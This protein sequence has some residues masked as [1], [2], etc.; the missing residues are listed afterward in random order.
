LKKNKL[1][2]SIIVLDTL[3]LDMFNKLIKHNPDLFKGFN[4]VIF[5]NCISPGS[6][7][8]PSHASMFTGL[9]QSQ[10]GCHET[11]QIKSLDIERIKLRKDTILQDLKAIGYSTY[12]VSANPYVHP[13]YG[14]TG[15]DEYIEESYFTDI[16]GSVIEVSR[17]LKPRVSKYR[18]IYGNDVFNLSKAIMKE[19]PKLFLDLVVSAT[20]LTPKAAIK[21]TKAKLIEGWPIEKGGKSMLKKIGAIKFKEPFFLFVNF[22]EA[23]DPYVGGKGNDF[24]WVT[25][26]L[27]EG[28]DEMLINKWKT[29]YEKASYKALKYSSELVKQLIKR[30]GEDQIIILTSD[31]GQLFN[32]HNFIGHGTVIFDEIVKVPLMVIVPE[33]FNKNI[34]KSGYQSL[35]NFPQFIKSVIAND[36]DPLSKLSS[37]KVYAETFSI[38]A[39]ISHMKGLDKRKMA[40]FDKYQK[41]SFG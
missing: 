18:N 10:H 3:K 26:F 14:F 20:T 24:N 8:L 7:T 41:R 29:L 38:P 33:S 22:M 17:E 13:V 40:K 21:K 34:K 31:H 2:I 27:K 19:D 15:F 5:Q 37:K 23:H 35:V 6:W 36:A 9:S 4:A 32:E 1:N 16:F 12:G 30:F 25:P 28:P 11:K 39:N